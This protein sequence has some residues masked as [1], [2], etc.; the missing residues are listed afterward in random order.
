M[1]F[2]EIERYKLIKQREKRVLK[3]MSLFEEDDVAEI[4]L[5]PSVVSQVASN[6]MATIAFD[7]Y[8]QAM[9]ECNAKSFIGILKTSDVLVNSVFELSDFI[10]ANSEGAEFWKDTL[11]PQMI[12]SLQEE[13][14]AR[15]EI[16][17]SLSSIRDLAVIIQQAGNNVQQLKGKGP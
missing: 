3:Y 2:S 16:V 4:S 6:P 1:S 13:M 7:S 12:K 10:P 17:R 8:N 9:I 15:N 11:K 5:P 14:I